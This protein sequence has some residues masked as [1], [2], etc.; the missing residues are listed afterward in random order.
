MKPL[1]SLFALLMTLS[2]AMSL[3]ACGTEENSFANEWNGKEGPWDFW[4]EKYEI[5]T[6][7]HV[8][9]E[10]K[11]GETFEKDGLSVKITDFKYEISEEATKK[12][13]YSDVMWENKLIFTY[14]LT[15]NTDDG[16]RL[17]R[18]CFIPYICNHPEISI[19]DFSSV[20]L[21]D[22]RDVY[23]WD[24]R[25]LDE[26]TKDDGLLAHKTV[27]DTVEI[28]HYRTQLKEE[29]KIVIGFAPGNTNISKVWETTA[30][31]SDGEEGVLNQMILIDVN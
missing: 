14:E 4:V 12:H 7:C 5:E 21:Y 28:T 17:S 18:E 13:D 24:K 9:D 15:N 27:T 31:I 8:I 22:D 1:K 11:L 30:P 2:I 20:N 29:P 6:Y 26:L 10:I 23:F 25:T 16:M 3:A 19:N